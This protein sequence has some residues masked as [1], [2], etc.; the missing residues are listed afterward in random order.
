MIAQVGYFLIIA[1]V[2]GPAGYGTFL[3]CT[4]LAAVLAPFSPLGTGRVLVK[5]TA[6]D[7]QSMPAYLGNALIITSAM[8]VILIM[9]IALLRHLLL[10]ASVSVA[11]VLAVGVADLILRS[12]YVRLCT[13]PACDWT[14]KAILLFD[15][16]VSM[17]PVPL[18]LCFSLPR[19]PSSRTMGLLLPGCERRRVVLWDLRDMRIVAAPQFTLNMVR[20]KEG[21][22]S[23]LRLPLKR[24]ITILIRQCLR[25]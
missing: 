14:S 6:R 12:G 13:G 5:Y 10:P 2:L 15:G 8:G 18:L 4:A 3:A 17:H 25:A 20:I 22:H 1:R 7:E 21:V 24:S 19:H 16:N 11:M 23:Q 9:V